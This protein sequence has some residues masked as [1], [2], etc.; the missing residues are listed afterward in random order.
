MKANMMI[1]IAAPIMNAIYTRVSLKKTSASSYV[2]RYIRPNIT[3]VEVAIMAANRRYWRMADLLFYVKICYF[4][5]HVSFGY[6]ARV[7]CHRLTRRVALQVDFRSLRALKTTD[8]ELRLI[9]NAA[10]M[11]ESNSPTNGYKTP[12]AKGTPR[13]L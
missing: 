8:A 12:A 3:I 11:G 10:N 9:A 5:K 7:K 6:F 1:A 2:F 4:S 13:A